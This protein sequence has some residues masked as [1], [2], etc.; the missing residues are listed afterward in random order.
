MFFC[1]PGMLF[2]FRG[3]WPPKARFSPKGVPSKEIPSPKGG[4]VL[5]KT[6]SG[7]TVSASISPCS[8]FLTGHQPKPGRHH[9]SVANHPHR[10]E[11]RCQ[12][13]ELR[14]Q[15]KNGVVMMDD[16]DCTKV[17]PWCCTGPTE[18]WREELQKNRDYTEIYRHIHPDGSKG[19]AVAK[20]N[21]T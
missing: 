17:K 15:S 18:A 1:V 3:L 20:F 16:V 10:S 8:N 6:R 7:K 19:F 21:D 13:S 5:A 2:S 4:V 12:S 9:H 14:N 11:L